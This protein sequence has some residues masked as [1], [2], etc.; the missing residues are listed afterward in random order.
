MSKRNRLRKSSELATVQAK[1]KGTELAS[2]EPVVKTG[3]STRVWATEQQ[4]ETAPTLTLSL[5]GNNFLATDTSGHTV[6]L[7]CDVNGLRVLKLML[8]AKELQPK[9]KLGTSNQPTQR[10]VDE[11][12]RN[13]QLEE[14]LKE[15]EVMNELKELF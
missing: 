6:S 10:M 15:I 11:F 1:P 3:V 14:D 13:K 7:P 12:L 2:P 5:R 8:R 4:K 9:P